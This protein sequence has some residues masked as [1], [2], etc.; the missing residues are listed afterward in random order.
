M[1]GYSLEVREWSLS[2]VSQAAGVVEQEVLGVVTKKVEGSAE[3][4]VGGGDGNGS[5]GDAI[6]VGGDGWQRYGQSGA[7]PSFTFF[8]LMLFRA[9][10]ARHVVVRSG[11][12]AN[13]ISREGDGVVVLIVSSYRYSYTSATTIRPRQGFS[14]ESGTLMEIVALLKRIIA[15]PGN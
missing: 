12:L 14:S 15:G 3:A 2:V 4:I 10:S 1:S 6:G 13:N 8:S 9:L 11:Y 5:V 7:V